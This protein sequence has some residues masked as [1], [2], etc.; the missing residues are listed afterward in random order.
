M[1]TEITKELNT[2]LYTRIAEIIEAA[3]CHVAR[4]ANLAMVTC[5]YQCELPVVFDTKRL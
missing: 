4:T 3:R 2:S 1:S 5:Y